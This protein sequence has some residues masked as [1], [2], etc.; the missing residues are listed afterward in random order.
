MAPV[1]PLVTVCINNYNY[2]RFVPNAVDSCLAQTYPHVETI[3]VDDGS[4][5]DSR[6][7]LDAYGDCITRV[8][9]RNSGQSAAVNAGVAAAR[10]EYLLLLDADDLLLP[11]TVARVVETFAA[12]DRLVRVQWPLELVDEAGSRTSLLLPPSDWRLPVGDLAAHA[13]RYRT[14]VWNPT[15]ASAYRV[16]ALQQVLPMP[17]STYERNT[18]PDLFLSETIVL[19]GPVGALQGVGGLYRVHAQNFSTLSRSD[20]VAFL[21]TKVSEIIAGQRHTRA[22]AT[23]LGMDWPAD[24][25]AALDWAFAAYRLA[26]LRLA[27]QDYPLS[28]DT[29][30]SL[31]VHGAISA[32]AHPHLTAKQRLT[33]AAWFVATGLAPR[34]RVPLL[35]RKSFHSSPERRLAAQQAAP[36]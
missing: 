10:G 34:S 24:P 27:P 36:A 4:T 21:R 31:A 5:D 29:V 18:G 16:S 17:E 9:Q 33:R 12:D 1:G 20:D 14:Y 30:R 2:G 11:D 22:L 3:V 35:V 28:G 25:G 26:L 15:S 23:R 8:F 7:V 32:L 6:A 19:L 13:R